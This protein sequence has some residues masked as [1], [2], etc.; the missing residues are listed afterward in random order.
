MEVLSNLHQSAKTYASIE[1]QKYVV[2]AQR[3]DQADGV[4]AA[5]KGLSVEGW[6]SSD[7]EEEDDED[8]NIRGG[9]AEPPAHTELSKNTSSSNKT[10]RQGVVWTRPS[11]SSRGHGC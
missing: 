1:D 9:R 6:E 2:E 7:I 3:L 10:T 11:T 4:T 8:G 5:L